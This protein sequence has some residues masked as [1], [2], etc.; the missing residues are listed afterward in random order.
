MCRG[1]GWR[2]AS[3]GECC[4]C[5]A[6]PYLKTTPHTHR[7][8]KPPPRG[9]RQLLCPRVMPKASGSSSS[10]RRS[11][12]HAPLFLSARSGAH[13]VDNARLSA[14]IA[15]GVCRDCA[16]DISGAKNGNKAGKAHGG[17]RRE[18][19]AAAAVCTTPRLRSRPL[20]RS[21]FIAPTGAIKLNAVVFPVLS[22]IVVTSTKVK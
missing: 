19:S 4:V 5:I 1:G 20:K 11:P 9:D 6:V 7:R 18:S 16:C 2:E 15:A 17:F 14:V 12:P 3:L 21:E 10:R 13:L 22:N 8:L